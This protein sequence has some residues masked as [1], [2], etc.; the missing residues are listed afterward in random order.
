MTRKKIDDFAYEVAENGSVY[1]I[2]RRVPTGKGRVGSRKIRD[3][4]IKPWF[5]KGFAYV[6]LYKDGKRYVKSVSTLVKKYFSDEK[7]PVNE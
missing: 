1:S 3:R 5:K 6:Q 7:S 4:R 2:E